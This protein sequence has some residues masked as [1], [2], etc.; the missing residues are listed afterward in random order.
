MR[1]HAV[2]HRAGVLACAVLLSALLAGIALAPPTPAAAARTRIAIRASS[3]AVRGILLDVAAAS[4]RNAWAVGQTGSA[5]GSPGALIVHWNGRT[6]RRVPSPRPSTGEDLEGVT[7]T[8]GRTAWAVGCTDCFSPKQRSLIER[9]NGTAWRRVAS[10]KGAGPSGT[11]YGVAAV[12]A[13][14]AWAVGLTGFGGP[15]KTMIL[16]WNGTGWKR[17]LSP[18]PSGGGV[19]IGVAATSPTNA[20]AVGYTS[21]LKA[22]VV[23]WNGTAWKAV[24]SPTVPGISSNLYAVAATPAGSAWAVGCT[25]CFG[26][27]PRS[28]TERWNGTV[29]QRVPSPTVAAGST[30]DGL[31]M[32]SARSAWAVGYTGAVTNLTRRPVILRW[33]GTGWQQVPSPSQHG[34]TSLYAVAVSSARG[35]WAVGQTGSYNNPRPRT[36]ILRWNGHSWK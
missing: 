15:S 12:S 21:G 29:W 17:V 27:H 33:N 8:F 6:W 35:A 36:V 20:W 9:W 16:H 32:G 22:L 14:D 11:L 3:F 28:L 31:A 5:N 26:R 25:A 4:A 19:L 10:P 30:L 18:N 24:P 13:R 2:V 23:R 34:G 1:S 7:A